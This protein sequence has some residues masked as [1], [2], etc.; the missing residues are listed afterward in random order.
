M[1]LTISVGA[2]VCLL[3][4]L[5]GTVQAQ[6]DDARFLHVLMVFD[7]NDP[8]I[9]KSVGLDYAEMSKMLAAGLPPKRYGV[10]ILAGKD[11]TPENILGH[12]SRLRMDRNDSLLFYYAGHGAWDTKSHYLQMNGGKRIRR[13][14]IRAA[15]ERRGAR[16]N[17]LLTDCCSIY[18][19]QAE[20]NRLGIADPYMYRDLFFRHRGTVDVTAARKGQVALGNQVNGGYFTMGLSDVFMYTPSRQIDRNRDGI[21]SWTEAVGAINVKTQANYKTRQRG[22]GPVGQTVQTPHIFGAVA[23]SVGRAIPR[24]HH[25]F[26]VSV[27]PVQGALRVKRVFEGSPA[28]WM[29]MQVGQIITGLAYV[30]QGRRQDFPMRRTE[31]FVGIIRQL[32][33]RATLIYQVPDRQAIGGSRDNYL[34]LSH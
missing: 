21:V 26:G 32:P 25:R 12:Y 2:V 5:A 16:L 1:R 33:A 3:S 13:T 7:T 14:D 34:R 15:M 24:S 19:G 6:V 22:I 17:I 18:T 27:E 4:G 30:N 31:D 10:S 29:N 28:H 11:V 9:G 23:R 20:F 8:T